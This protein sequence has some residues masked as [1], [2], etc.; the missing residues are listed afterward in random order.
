VSRSARLTS[1]SPLPWAPEFGPGRC[2]V[3]AEAGVNH[4]G[5]VALAEKLIESAAAAGADAV[6]FQTW[7]TEKLV[8]R[9]APLAGYQARSGT[10]TSQFDMLKSLELPPSA[11]VHLK[12]VAHERGI[13][14]ASSPDEEESADFLASLDVDFIKIGS[15][16]V[17]NLPFLRHVAR[18]R[19]PLILSTGMSDLTEVRE[20][21]SAIRGEGNEELVLLH[22]VSSYPAPL[23][24]AN[25]R[26]MAALDGEFHL[27]VGFSDHT[28]GTAASLAAVALGARV[29]ERHLTLDRAL[30]GPDHAASLDPQQFAALVTEIREIEVSLGDGIKRVA[31][32]ELDT[33]TTMRRVVVARRRL[34]AGTCVKA[35][36]VELLRAGAGVGIALLP[37]VLG[38]R[39]RTDVAHGAP[40]TPETLE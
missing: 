5:D 17:T 32:S 38:R 12:E 25:V 11:F 37:S 39:L 4:N 34:P 19:R 30:P 24:E 35:D 14:F 13:V 33:R 31:D 10:E 20:A 16:E 18:L 7:R 29:L 8:T 23:A 6:K 28:L 22:C 9:D 26:V 40:I 2:F 1:N 27:P 21:V 15:P 3:I 36:D